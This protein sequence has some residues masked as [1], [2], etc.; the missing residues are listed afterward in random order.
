MCYY[1]TY[2]HIYDEHESKHFPSDFLNWCGGKNVFNLVG[3][4][5][6]IFLVLIG[7]NRK[8]PSLVKYT[9]RFYLWV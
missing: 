2:L 9:G 6:L 1:M 8:H 3:K 7:S 4:L 5:C